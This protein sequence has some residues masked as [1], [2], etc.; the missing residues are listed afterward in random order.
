[1]AKM[2]FD[3]G[4]IGGG[5]AGLTAA[6]G[7]A[8]LG[9]KV[10][11]IER[12]PRLGGDCLHYG[13][14]PSKTLIKT[15]SVYHQMK[16]AQRFGLPPLLIPPVDFKAVRERILSV[17]ARIQEH[18]SEERF[19]GLGVQVEFGPASFVDEHQ[20]EVDSKAFS[21]DKWLIATGSS[22][23]AP[24]LPGLAGAGYLTNREIF[25]LERL[26]ESLLV[27]GGGPI[28]CELAQAFARLG[29]RVSLVQRSSQLLGKED[30][31]L[32]DLARASL[33][34]DGVRIFTGTE[35]LRVRPDGGRKGVA[36]RDSGGREVS[37]EAEEIL[38]ALGRRPNL[39]GLG[40]EAAGVEFTPKGIKVD[41]RLRSSQKH[42][43]AAGDVT[44]S[45]QFT[46]AAGY[47]GGVV[48]AN[49]VFRLP[50]KADYTWLPRCTYTDPELAVIGLN[51]TAAKKAGIEYELW[52]ED[53]AAND[54]SLAEGREEGRIKLLLD[55][56]EN[57][58]GV[59]IAGLHAGE[60]IAEWV[61][62]LNGKVKLSTL[63]GAVHPYPT[64]AEINKR[65][66]GGV[67]APKLFSDTVKKGLKFFFHTK[68]RACRLAGE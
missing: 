32:A 47:E 36:F 18:D 54:R 42:I 22:P 50:K 67:M 62:A 66:A 44:G 26:P 31:D 40:L 25:Y 49:A 38:A 61:A 17:I 64:L 10:L 12:E 39:E 45:H 53:F 33:E 51:E 57:V 30:S 20:V 59:Q 1:M 28:A 35:L 24:A 21:A 65:A 8:Q 60:L 37:L 68:G 13:C 55:G 14:V 23:A 2:D 19:C 11:L 48:L 15:A 63:A 5:A 29:S 46:H 27:L 58:L 9:S 56:K 34:A 4:V 52:V 3:L 7:A 16:D 41:Q 43:F 6:S